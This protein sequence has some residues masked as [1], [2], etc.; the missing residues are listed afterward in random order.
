MRFVLALL[1]LSLPLTALAQQTDQPDGTIAV[2]DSAQQDAAIAVRIRAILG[3][4]DGYGDVTVTVSSGIVTLRGTTVDTT[5]AQRLNEIARRVQGVVA[6]KNEVHET[7]DVVERLNPAMQRLRTRLA[8]FAAMLPLISVGVLVFVLITGTGI[9]LARR[10]NPW[11][12]IA[13]NLFIADIYRQVVR[14]AFGIGGM[15][16]ALDEA[17]VAETAR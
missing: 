9:L 5:A 3:E 11:D 10:K 7:T 12:R 2:E 15:V 8:Q 16:V 14:L 1:L 13:P 4:L 17:H 6:I